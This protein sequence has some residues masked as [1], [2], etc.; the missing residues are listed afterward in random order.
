MKAHGYSHPSPSSS[1]SSSSECRILLQ[2]DDEV[3]TATAGQALQPATSFDLFAASGVRRRG[4][5]HGNTDT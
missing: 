3:A 2:P 4:H 1:S 5:H